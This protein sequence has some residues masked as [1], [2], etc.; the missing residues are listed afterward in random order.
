V[1]GVFIK[2]R[3]YQDLLTANKTKSFFMA[4]VILIL[5]MLLLC[6]MLCFHITE[7]FAPFPGGCGGWCRAAK[8]THTHNIVGSHSICD[9]N[10]QCL[11]TMKKL[12][13]SSKYRQ[14]RRIVRKG[15]V[16]RGRR[17][18]SHYLIMM[19]IK[20]STAKCHEKNTTQQNYFSQNNV[21]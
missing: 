1:E 20:C 21:N 13:T 7:S 14:F 2:R 11:R 9:R 17:I 12:I 4:K 16:I 15:K 3:I 5:T 10:V 19:T 18:W 8:R 6:L